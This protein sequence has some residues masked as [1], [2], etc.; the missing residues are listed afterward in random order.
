MKIDR[1]ESRRI[2]VEIRRVL[3]QTWDPLGIRGEPNAQDEYDTYS[4]GV[5]ELLV[6]GA[7][8]DEI[9]NHL[10]QII[11]DRMGLDPARGAMEET[12]R[13]LRGIQLLRS[14]AP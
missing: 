12:V 4:G 5:C 9:S 3:L 7:T 2:R 6:S 10:W 11:K 8:D 14:P 1:Y 13:A